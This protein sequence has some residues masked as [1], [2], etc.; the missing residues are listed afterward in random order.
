MKPTD[1]SRLL[2]VAAPSDARGSELADTL[3]QLG[4]NVTLATTPEQAAQ[5]AQYKGAIIVLSPATKDDP[6]VQAAINVQGARLFPFFAEP[7]ILPFGKWEAN[8]VLLRGSIP[9]AAERLVAAVDAPPAVDVAREA[10]EARA[11]KEQ[12]AAV[13]QHIS[14]IVGGFIAILL[15]IGL[16]IFVNSGNTTTPSGTSTAS[17]A[18]PTPSGPAVYQAAAPGGACDQNGATWGLTSDATITC[19]SDAA[20]L[21][22]KSAT[23]DYQFITF[24]T[25]D[26]TF[27]STYQFAFTGKIT[28]GDA[29]TVIFAGIQQQP[30]VG[31]EVV[32]VSR[33]GHWSLVQISNTGKVLKTLKSGTLASAVT[34]FKFAVSIDGLGMHVKLNGKAVASDSDELGDGSQVIL[35]GVAD[36][37]GTSGYAASFANFVYTPPAS[38]S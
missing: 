9:D 13:R 32:A 38:G 30:P 33:D 19:A 37:G 1:T 24:K 10:A 11:A 36:P 17:S 26:G 35:F 27:P 14:Y 2:V 8:P 3:H 22:V 18:T 5:A 25:P 20:T 29:Q 15:I 4:R 12:Q 28:K 21:S 6:T 34:S 23:T 7:M 31:M 16:V